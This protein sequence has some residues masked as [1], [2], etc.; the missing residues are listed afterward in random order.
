[1]LVVNAVHEDGA[2][3]AE[4]RGA[5]DAEIASLAGWLGLVLERR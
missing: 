4:E 5:V 1:M 2:W 3:S